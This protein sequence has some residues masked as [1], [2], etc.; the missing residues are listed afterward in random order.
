[1]ISF[2][3]IAAYSW[4]PPDLI[5]HLAP[6]ASLC[7]LLML[8]D[9]WSHRQFL[10]DTA[11]D[12]F[13]IPATSLDKVSLHKSSDTS[14]TCKQLMAHQFVFR[15]TSLILHLSAWGLDAFVPHAEVHHPLLS[16]DFHHCHKLLVTYL[17]QIFCGHL[18]LDFVLCLSPE[19]LNYCCLQPMTIPQDPLLFILSDIPT[20]MK[21]KFSG[22]E[23]K[24]GVFHQIPLTGLSGWTLPQHLE[25]SKLC[26]AKLEINSVVLMGNICPS[27][28]P[29]VS[30][31]HMLPKTNVKWRPCGDYLQM[32][33]SSIPDCYPVPHLQDFTS[34]L[35]GTSLSTGRSYPGLPP[36]SSQWWCMQNCCHDPFGLCEFIHMHDLW[37][38]GQSFQQMIDSVLQGGCH[39]FLLSCKSAFV[40]PDSA[41]Y[42]CFG[43]LFHPPFY[44]I[45]EGK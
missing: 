13:V 40:E 8:K 14:V 36:N 30:P 26:A 11:A 32:T 43:R 38:S 24:R 37:N 18:W 31:H 28:S 16:A 1:M 45:E 2:I 29:W 10:V 23:A 17:Q 12:I 25:P 5:K 7:S 35:A 27:S 39:T 42:T 21:S 19:P 33:I 15:S 41:E 44:L 20:F 9:R 22:T 3:C 6:H 34:S 4:H